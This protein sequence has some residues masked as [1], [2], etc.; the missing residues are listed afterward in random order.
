[1]I[2]RRISKKTFIRYLGKTVAICLQA[3]LI[4]AFY[5]CMTDEKY[6]TYLP[7]VLGSQTWLLTTVF[8]AAGFSDHRKET[9]NIEIGPENNQ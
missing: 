9:K 4:I 1:M 2:E 3:M 6:T 8:A 7:V 5:K